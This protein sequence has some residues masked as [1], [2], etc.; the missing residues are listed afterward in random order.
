MKI[1]E[2]LDSMID[3]ISKFSPTFAQLIETGISFAPTFGGFLNYIKLHRFSIRLKEE[4]EKIDEISRLVEN[5]RLSKEFIEKHVFPIALDDLIQEHE[6]AKFTLI[7]NGYANVFIDEHM[8]ESIILTHFDTL[9]SLRYIDI[10]RLFQ[11][12]RVQN[13]KKDQF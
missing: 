10:R 4:K 5:S 9:R 3:D 13:D 6:D 12:A 11:L 7:L 2:Y 8:D 1:K